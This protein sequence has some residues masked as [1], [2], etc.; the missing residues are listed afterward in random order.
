[1]AGGDSLE[2]NNDIE[3]LIENLTA[4]PS[5]K[6]VFLT[7]AMCDYQSLGFN[8]DKYYSDLFFYPNETYKN[9]FMEF[10]ELCNKL[11]IK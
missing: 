10:S 4:D 2:T 9:L 1:M 6:I 11:G 5:T 3:C 8:E 7:A